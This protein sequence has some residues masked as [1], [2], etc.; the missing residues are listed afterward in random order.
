MPFCCAA[1]G[2]DVVVIEGFS[3]A[4]TAALVDS[5]FQ[6]RQSEMK[7]TQDER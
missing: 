7:P 1:K 5:A 6:A 2:R 3:P 4:V